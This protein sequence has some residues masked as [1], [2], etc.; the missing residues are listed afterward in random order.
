MPMTF[1]PITWGTRAYLLAKDELLEFCNSIN[2]KTEPR[3]SA[4]GLFFLRHGDWINE[5]QGPPTLPADWSSY[6]L[7]KP[8]QAEVIEMTGTRTGKLNV[9]QAQ[10]IRPGMIL[11]NGRNNRFPCMVRVVSSDKESCLIRELN[12]LIVPDIKVGDRVGS[13]PVPEPD[14]PYDGIR[15]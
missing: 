4:N 3:A 1:L 10:G 8:V 13:Q 11:Q 14:K 7:P 2:L 5:V 9:G 12:E 15:R 6:L